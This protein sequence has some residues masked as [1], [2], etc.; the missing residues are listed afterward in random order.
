MG[1]CCSQD[2]AGPVP[3][4]HDTLRVKDVLFESGGVAAP[5]LCRPFRWGISLHARQRPSCERD[6]RWTDLRV[7][8]RRRRDQTGGNFW[9]LISLSKSVRPFRI[10]SADQQSTLRDCAALYLILCPRIQR[11]SVELIE[12]AVDMV[13]LRYGKQSIFF[14]TRPQR[15]S[16]QPMS[17]HRRGGPWRSVV[18]GGGGTR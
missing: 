15:A 2:L 3:L 5:P 6:T 16:E 4:A 9:K 1:N 12:M 11:A 18:F 17:L 13:V 10:G 14:R 7:R 8:R